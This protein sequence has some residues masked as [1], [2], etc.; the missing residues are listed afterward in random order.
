MQAVT[1]SRVYNRTLR[2]LSTINGFSRIRPNALK[3]F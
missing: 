3:A 1:A 2:R